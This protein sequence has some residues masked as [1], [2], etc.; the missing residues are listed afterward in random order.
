MLTGA[1]NDLEAP[2]MQAS[3]RVSIIPSYATPQVY[4]DLANRKNT[5]TLPVNRF[6]AYRAPAGALAININPPPD[7]A[8]AQS[9]GTE[10]VVSV[11]ISFVHP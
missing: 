4:T 1:D 6:L 10:N 7:L 2:M 3:A 5:H 8:L 11:K 9:T